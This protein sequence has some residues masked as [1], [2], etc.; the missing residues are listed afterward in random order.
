MNYDIMKLVEKS[1]L[2]TNVPQFHFCMFEKGNT[3]L[4]NQ[5]IEI[6]S[7]NYCR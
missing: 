5:D 4:Q 6:G 3:E 7:H 2:K 1:S